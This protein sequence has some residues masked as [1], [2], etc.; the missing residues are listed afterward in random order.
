MEILY[1]LFFPLVKRT[2]KFIHNY[3]T[4]DICADKAKALKQAAF[5]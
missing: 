1:K 2:V 3:V 4:T 5:D